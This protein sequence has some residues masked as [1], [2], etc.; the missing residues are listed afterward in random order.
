MTTEISN[1]LAGLS[2]PELDAFVETGTREVVAIGREADLDYQ[3]LVARD[4]L[5]GLGLLLGMPHYHG[6][7]IRP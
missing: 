1:E 4:A 6:V 7:I 2:V 3:A 5:D